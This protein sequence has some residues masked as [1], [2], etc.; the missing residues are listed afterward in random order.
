ML[1]KAA[2][3]M[4]DAINPQGWHKAEMLR[5]ALS[6]EQALAAD[7]AELI[8]ALRNRHLKYDTR[9]VM[10]KAADMLEARYGT[11]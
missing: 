3:E 10:L 5:K 2:Q 11:K 6:E 4:L 8:N 7:N 9:E 1:Q